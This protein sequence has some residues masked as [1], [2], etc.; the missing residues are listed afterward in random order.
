MCVAVVA[1]AAF[2]VASHLA[3]THSTSRLT[4][5]P[6]FPT[7]AAD[8]VPSTSPDWQG[9]L[10]AFPNLEPKDILFIGRN[11]VGGPGGGDV[12]LEVTPQ[13]FADLQF[14]LTAIE[15]Q[16][17]C[18]VLSITTAGCPVEPPPGRAA[19]E[20]DFTSRAFAPSVG[21]PEDPV[22]GSAHCMLGPYWQAKLGKAELLARAA[23]P[24][25]GDV[26]VRVQGERT[27]LAGQA[28]TTLRGELLH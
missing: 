25:G 12:L 28:V 21:A 24:R 1:L 2:P 10:T 27:V 18:R 20:Y 14:D 17:V 16:V 6:Q 23:S 4:S 19:T 13:A 5:R 26:R 11:S 3:S 22:C 9:V 8:P 15:K 7:C